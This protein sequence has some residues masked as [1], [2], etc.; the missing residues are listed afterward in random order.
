MKH[1]LADYIAGLTIGQGRY[2][3]QS[4][5]LLPWQARFLRGAF[6]TDDD[7]AMTCARGSGKTTFI[8]ALGAAAVDVDGPL[9]QPMAETMIV[10]S[11]FDQGLTA[12]RHVQQFLQPSFE[13]YGVGGRRGRFR[14]Q[15]SANRATIE[16]RET[17]ARVAVLGS[18]PGRLHSHAPS[19]VIGDE[20]AQW[21]G[22][23]I[24]AMLSALVTSMGKI[25]GSRALWIG[26][27]A[28]GVGSSV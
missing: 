16:D 12:F 19:L 6:A 17:G 14:V 1:T 10:A 3:G 24:D 21:P 27:R 8:S 9:V 4:F 15:D 25:P 28:A 7:A 20:L 23:K 26:T 11:S 13:R 18:D 22:T 5:K 2:A